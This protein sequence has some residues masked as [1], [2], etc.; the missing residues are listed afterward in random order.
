MGHVGRKKMKNKKI[1]TNAIFYLI[2]MVVACVLNLAVSALLVKIVNLFIE[3][4]YFEAAIV[5][6]VSSLL[7]SGVILGAVAFFESHKTLEFT[8]APMLFSLLM[9]GGAH[10][11]LCIVLM[12][13]PFMAGGVRELAGVLSMG[14]HFNSASMI[15]DIYLWMYLVAFAIHL[16]Y[17]IAV[18]M[19]CGWLGKW[20]RLRDRSKLCISSKDSDVNG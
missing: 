5:R 11:I 19:L 2:C 13:T 1:G 3:V 16:A 17:E 18:C 20:K 4:E 15:E 9:A 12:F 8:P 7:T 10:L 6:I 14:D